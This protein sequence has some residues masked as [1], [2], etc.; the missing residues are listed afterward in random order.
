MWMVI[1]DVATKLP[2]FS[3]ILSLYLEQGE[4]KSGV[5]CL[6]SLDVL[7]RDMTLVCFVSLL[8]TSHRG[9]GRK[10]ARGGANGCASDTYSLLPRWIG[11]HRP[12][13]LTGWIPL[14]TWD[15][16][17]GLSAAK[18]ESVP[19][20]GEIA[21]KVHAIP[22]E[23][24]V[25]DSQRHGALGAAGPERW[26]CCRGGSH[27]CCQ[28][29]C[30]KIRWFAWDIRACVYSLLFFNVFGY[31]KETIGKTST[32]PVGAEHLE[33][34]SDKE[35]ATTQHDRHYAL[36]QQTWSAM[37]WPR[38]ARVQLSWAGHGQVPTVCPEEQPPGGVTK[39]D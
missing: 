11:L 30:T 23:H 2:F 35:A 17:R 1:S 5:K 4:P 22:L 8:L 19:W 25:R 32:W 28:W 16:T 6:M 15:V 14:L 36:Q 33:A 21:C 38:Q 10:Q 31:W 18:K 27:P 26:P 34:E 3:L 29:L 7:V 9:N 24:P 12:S 37:A 39:P 20:T 13:A